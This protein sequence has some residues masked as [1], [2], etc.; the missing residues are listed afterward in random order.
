VKNTLR[1]P[2][3]PKTPDI[4]RNTS[5]MGGLPQHAQPFSATL[6]Y[7]SS[8]TKAKISLLVSIRQPPCR[9]FSTFI[10]DASHLVTTC[11]DTSGS[12][13][14]RDN[15]SHEQRSGLDLHIVGVHIRISTRRWFEKGPEGF[16]RCKAKQ[17]LCEKG[18]G[19]SEL[20]FQTSP[21]PGPLRTTFDY[22]TPPA[23]TPQNLSVLPTGFV[24]VLDP[25]SQHVQGESVLAFF[26]P[27]GPL[28]S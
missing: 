17:G 28:S 5:R 2:Q 16:H 12:T 25:G 10:K 19:G 23:S 26:I 18:E 4:R 14:S 1:A 13:R 11:W 24:V 27:S 6:E 20:W 21:R 3:E 22:P 9:S 8:S 7:S 15:E